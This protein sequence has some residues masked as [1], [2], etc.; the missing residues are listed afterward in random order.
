MIRHILVPASGLTGDEV[1]FETA[2]TV[3]RADSAHLQ[4]LHVRQDVIALLAAMSDG[5][6]GGAAYVQNTA[7][8]FE[9]D[10]TAQEAKA[11]EAVAA[12]CANAGITLDTTAVP[13]MKISAEFAVETGDAAGWVSQYGR[14]TDLLVT[15]RPVGDQLSIGLIETAL[16]ATGWPV[17]IAGRAVP[18]SLSDVMMIAWKDRPESACA[19]AGAMP[20]IERAER[21]VIVSV[22]EDGAAP[23]ASCE[24][25]QRSLRWHNPAV[26]IMHLPRGQRPAAEVMLETGAR[27]SARLLVMGG[28]SHSRLRETIFGGFTRHVLEQ[29]GLDIPVLMMH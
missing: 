3:A 24:Q 20:F 12:F 8:Q 9:A 21:V 2:L 1:A 17:M 22:E 15:R 27:L 14:F 6:F 16:A 19:V 5:G 7:D 18:A 26:E 13:S 28:Y 29:V 25:L 4:F 11:R 10:A 23:Q